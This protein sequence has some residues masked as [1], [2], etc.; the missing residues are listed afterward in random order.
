[1]LPNLRMLSLQWLPNF[2]DISPGL[3]VHAAKLRQMNIVKCPKYDSIHEWSTQAEVINDRQVRNEVSYVDDS[4][5][6]EEQEKINTPNL[7][8]LVLEDL[9]DLISSYPPG[10]VRS[11]PTL[12]SLII[13]ECE[14]LE[15]IFGYA[16]EKHDYDGKVIELALP[17]LANLKLRHLPRLISFGGDLQFQLKF[18]ALKYCKLQDCPK[19]SPTIRASVK[20]F[21]ASHEGHNSEL[22]VPTLT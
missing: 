2:I 16:S 4:S 17:R 3:K 14:E 15:Q 6:E 13:R 5:F 1:M 20:N 19:L 8:S 18:Q 11:L 12:E 21:L 9:P 22:N 7:E 10:A